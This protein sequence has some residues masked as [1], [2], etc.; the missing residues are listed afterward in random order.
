MEEDIQSFLVA[1]PSHSKR[2]SVFCAQS[3][4]NVVQALNVMQDVNG[5]PVKYEFKFEMG[6]PWISMARNNLARY[7]MEKDYTDM[8]FID[9]DI[10]F[11]APAFVDLCWAKEE[12]I[13]GVYPKKQDDVCFAM[14]LK[15]DADN[16]PINKD[17]VFEAISLPTGFMKIKRVVF[18]KIA[19]AHPELAYADPIN[20]K[21]TYNFFAEYVEDGKFYGDDYGFCNHWTR[22]GGKCWVLPDVTFSH[23]GEKA[24][25]GNLYEYIKTHPVVKNKE[26]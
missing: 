24:Y 12:L 5:N 4:M 11:P 18:D 13:S 22:L 19:A 15:T 9:D 26:A 2:M 23:S 10:G 3:L 21:K 20:G 1:V 7:F 16:H 17:G 14:L 25:F 6:N 8:I